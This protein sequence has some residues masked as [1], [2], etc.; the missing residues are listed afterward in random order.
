MGMVRVRMLVSRAGPDVNNQIGDVVAVDEEEARRMTAK[1]QAVYVE[2]KAIETTA[3]VEEREHHG[4]ED[5]SSQP[6]KRGR[7][8]TRNDGPG[9]KTP[10]P[11]A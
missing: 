3:V 6:A 9:S 10:E 2:E 11:A 8:R 5:A 4:G 7:K 1:G